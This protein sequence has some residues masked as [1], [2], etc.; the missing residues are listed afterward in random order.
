MHKFVSRWW[1]LVTNFSKM[2]SKWKPVWLFGMRTVIVFTNPT[3]S[4]RFKSVTFWHCS[5][6]LELAIW[7][8]YS[9]HNFTAWVVLSWFNLL[10][11]TIEIFPSHT[12]GSFPNFCRRKFRVLTSLMS[13]YS[14]CDKFPAV[15]SLLRCCSL[16]NFEPW[17]PLLLRAVFARLLLNELCRWWAEAVLQLHNRKR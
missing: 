14:A 7:C 1:R 10:F 3:F 13:Y 4:F 2:S 6:F 16:G 9:S 11:I 12:V 15:L 5:Y 17:Y 8:A